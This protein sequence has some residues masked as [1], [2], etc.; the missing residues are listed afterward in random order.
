M[1]SSLLLCSCLSLGAQNGKLEIT[2][3]RATFGHLGAVRPKGKG[4]LPGDVASFTFDIQNLKFDGD[5]KASYSVAIEVR[6]G[7]GELFFKQEPYNS[8]AQNFFGG[9]AVPCSAQVEIPLSA[10]PGTYTWRVTIHDRLADQNA[11]ATGNGQVLPA[12]FGIIRVGTYA[13][14]D[15][16]VPVPPVGVVGSTLHVSFAAVGFARGKNKQPDLAVEMKI[17]DDKGTV[18]TAKP[19]AGH[20]KSDIPEGLKIIPLQYGLT[21]N[22]P[23]NYTV[24]LTARCELCDKTVSVTFPVRILP[25]E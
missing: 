20:V 12:D 23:G 24:E 21:L 25:M 22:R 11:V 1:L 3:P 8:I 17:R 7:E 18:T 6:N 19:I 10:K 15:G 16:K 9:N 14:A 13:D 5:G 4:L 2:N